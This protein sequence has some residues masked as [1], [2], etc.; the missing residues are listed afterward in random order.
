MTPLCPKCGWIL[1]DAN[2]DEGYYCPNSACPK[3]NVEVSDKD[4]AT[5]EDYEDYYC[6]NE[7]YDDDYE[8]FVHFFEDCEDEETND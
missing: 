2:D 5:Y 6:H 1:E 4:V 8:D 3:F 7:G